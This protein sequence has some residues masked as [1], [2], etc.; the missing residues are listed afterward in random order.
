M[1][2]GVDFFLLK[3]GELSM[4]QPTAAYQERWGGGGR[5]KN[6][7]EM[8]NIKIWSRYD[9]VSLQIINYFFIALV[10][11]PAQHS[12]S[13]LCL[14]QMLKLCIYLKNRHWYICSN[15]A[16]QLLMNPYLLLPCILNRIFELGELYYFCFHR[17]WTHWSEMQ[18]ALLPWAV[19][20]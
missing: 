2:Q 17:S 7:R 14:P 18:Q 9:N 4:S 16:K 13:S 1:A 8:L 6:K 3:Q 19:L 12:R 15:Y 10:M 11:A 20:E 5:R